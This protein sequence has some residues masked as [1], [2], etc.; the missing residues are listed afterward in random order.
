MFY[1]SRINHLPTPL[2][3]LFHRIA[4]EYGKPGRC[5]ERLS[6]TTL[7]FDE[8]KS[9]YYD[10][11]NPDEIILTPANAVLSVSRFRDPLNG[12]YVFFLGLDGN[13]L[14]MDMPCGINHIVI[15]A[16]PSL[17]RVYRTLKSFRASNRNKYMLPS[18]AAVRARQAEQE[19]E[20]PLRD[21]AADRKLT[22]R[23]PGCDCMDEWKKIAV[24]D[25]EMLFVYPTQFAGILLEH[26]GGLM[27]VE[28]LDIDL[29]IRLDACRDC[30]VRNDIHARDFARLALNLDKLVHRR[31]EFIRLHVERLCEREAMDA[32]DVRALHQCHLIRV[33]ERHL[34][35]EDNEA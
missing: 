23:L 1:G 3:V 6:G 31:R 17:D 11:R 14:H 2:F 27:A 16:N 29:G 19:A 7:I 25:T 9:V 22:G 30:I 8:E 24:F 26:L 34:R 35:A 13:D 33:C 28:C 32:R 10:S 5:S 18:S 4:Q 21:P 20:E 15:P 12:E